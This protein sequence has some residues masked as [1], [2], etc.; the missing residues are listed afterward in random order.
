MKVIKEIETLDVQRNLGQFFVESSKYT[1]VESSMYPFVESSKYP[2][3]PHSSSRKEIFKLDLHGLQ[4]GLKCF[5]NN[6]F[7]S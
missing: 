7:V 3:I 6:D 1:F 4:N 5:E 2:F